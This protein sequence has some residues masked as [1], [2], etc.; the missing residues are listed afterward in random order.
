M[1]HEMPFIRRL[2]R[3]HVATKL[4][5]ALC[6]RELTIGHRDHGCTEMTPGRAEGGV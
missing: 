1:G 2:W 4:T 6:T 5:S 3:Q